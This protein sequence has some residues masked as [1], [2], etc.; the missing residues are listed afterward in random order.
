MNND[1]DEDGRY[2]NSV[3]R[4]NRSICHGIACAVA[5]WTSP[6]KPELT[7][8]H[9][10]AAHRENLRMVWGA[11]IADSD[12]LAPAGAA[13]TLHSHGWTV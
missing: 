4:G 13:Y 5:Y 7:T 11:A 6:G 12:E 2:L 9:T 10:A 3:Y 1:I 8:T